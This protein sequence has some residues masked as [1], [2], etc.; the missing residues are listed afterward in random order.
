MVVK[1]DPPPKKD[2]PPKADPPPKKDPPKSKVMGKV[3]FASKPTGAE[4]WVD[5][6][7]TG[8]KTPVPQPQALELSVGKHKVVFKLDGKSSAPKEFEVL[9]ENKD[10]PLVVKGEI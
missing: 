1:A 5:G 10:K 9:D 8:K 6:K 2:P 4:V 3:A 7:N